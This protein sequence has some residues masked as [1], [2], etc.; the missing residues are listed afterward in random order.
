MSLPISPGII[1]YVR[2]LLR[3]NLDRL[4][5]VRIDGHALVADGTRDLNEVLDS[6]YPSLGRK[7]KA[8]QELDRL[9]IVHQTLSGSA[10]TN[11]TELQATETAIFKIFGFEFCDP[12]GK[13]CILIVDDAPGDLQLLASTFKQQGYRVES[14]SSGKTAI[15]TIQDT[16]PD[17]V[18]LD[19]L[20]PEMSGYEVCEEL[21]KISIVRDVPIIFV[22]SSDEVSSKVKAFALGGADFILKPFQMEE[23]CARVENQLRLRNLQKRLEAQNLRLQDEMH[24]RHEVEARYRGLFDNALEPMF[25]AD[26]SG[27]FIAVNGSYSRLY[28]YGKPHEM[29]ELVS[30]IGIQ[31]YDDPKRL[32]E[33]HRQLKE[34]GQIIGAESR[35][36][37]YDGSVIWVSENMRAVRNK[38]GG[39]IYYEGTVQDITAV[40]MLTSPRGN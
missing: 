4:R 39:V 37:R 5:F 11:R 35:I 20:M 31:L 10:A 1:Y 33:L 38:Q 16:L 28:G 22:S 14:S 32:M 9:T 6:L 15:E 29:I 26:L 2:K 17:V 18:I 8:I 3:Q 25:Q 23:V 24:E 12:M 19:I 30:D 7:L 21:K 13:G 27:R 36:R 34:T 40:K